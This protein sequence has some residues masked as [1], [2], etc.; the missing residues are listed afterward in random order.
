MTHE[1]MKDLI[2]VTIENCYDNSESIGK[3][4]KI[5]QDTRLATLELTGKLEQVNR[6][7]NELKQQIDRLSR[8]NK[9]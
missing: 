3:L 2:S 6:E 8:R 5:E 1:E 7:I 4:I 9:M